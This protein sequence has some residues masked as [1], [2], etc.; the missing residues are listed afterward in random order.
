MSLDVLKTK[1][2]QNNISGV[3]LFVGK[4]EYTKDHYA[5]QMRKNVDSSPIPEFNHCVFDASSQSIS[6][7][8]DACFSL[9][10]MWDT[11]LIE[12][13]NI[14]T[15]R[16]KESEALEYE[17]VFCEIPD[18]LT[19]LIVLR[20][21]EYNTDP[22]AKKAPKSGISAFVNLVK[23]Y[24]LVVDFETET[25]DKL[26]SW[27]S[28]HFN[29]KKIKYEYNVPRELLNHCGSNMYVLQGEITKLAA[30][31]DTNPITARDVKK[32]CSQNVSYK[33]FD[34][35]NC[36]NK[37]DIVSAKRIL[38]GLK[39]R[40]EDYQLAVGFLAKNYAD[41]LLVK[42]GLDSGKSPDSLASDLKIQSWR[43]GRIAS[44]VSGVELSAIAYS[45]SVIADAD[46][47]LKTF[48][49]NPKKILELAFYRICSY[50]RKT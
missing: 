18:Y 1:L 27:I 29:A 49:G 36:L 8:E 28:R 21:S 45:V 37:R 47:K 30:A 43:I 10:Y 19:V 13:K 22:Q 42:T 48:R 2:K 31:Y 16:L 32:Y 38:D 34:I 17:R 12:I 6:E 14:D 46:L 33:Y 23:K 15:S 4:E 11:K 7:L 41:M 26:V 25:A 5:A 20:D 9:P 35:A 3:Y 40:R 39:L 50:G 44:A 24:G